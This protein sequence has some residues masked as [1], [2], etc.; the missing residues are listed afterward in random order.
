VRGKNKPIHLTHH[1]S[2]R[3]ISHMA[4]DTP[5][6]SHLGFSSSD[7][8]KP[9]SHSSMRTPDICSTSFMTIH[10]DAV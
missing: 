9:Q 1:V 10:S 4:E 5:T 6:F 8:T 2:I 3:V 7:I